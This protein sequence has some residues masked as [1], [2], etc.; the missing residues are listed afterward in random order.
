MNL[1]SALPSRI[2][3]RWIFGSLI[4]LTLILGLLIFLFHPRMSLTQGIMVNELNPDG[5]PSPDLEQ[6]IASL[7]AFGIAL[8]FKTEEN[9]AT[10]KPHLTLLLENPEVDWVFAPNTG[11]ELPAELTDRFVSLGIVRY[12]PVGFFIRKGEQRIHRLS[13]LKGKRIFIWA[14]PKVTQNRYSAP[15]GPRPPPTR[16]T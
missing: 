12:V 10:A 9:M 5:S 8:A 11:A 7:K 6:A 16:T 3:H 1:R 14:P 15:A 13:D 4:G 2:A